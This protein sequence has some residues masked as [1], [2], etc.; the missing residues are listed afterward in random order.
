MCSHGTRADDKFAQVID[1]TFAGKILAVLGFADRISIQGAGLG[2]DL[3]DNCSYCWVVISTDPF[4]GSL[5]L[6]SLYLRRNAVMGFLRR[7]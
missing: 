6:K 1:L 7:T 2:D 5:M 3:A 4:G